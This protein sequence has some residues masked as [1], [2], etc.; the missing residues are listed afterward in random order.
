MTGKYSS[1]KVCPTG[2]TLDQ[3]GH[4]MIHVQALD[5]GRNGASDVPYTK[6][7]TP[8]T[9]RVLSLSTCA[10]IAAKNRKSRSTLPPH[11][12]SGLCSAQHG[13]YK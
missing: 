2:H 6:L 7:W 13:L 10:T 11:G 3:K 1:V 12:R 8:Q 5:L 9:H 4:E